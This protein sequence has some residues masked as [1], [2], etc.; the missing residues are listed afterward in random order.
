MWTLPFQAIP[1]RRKPDC[2]LPARLLGQF[3]VRCAAFT[4]VIFYVFQIK[5]VHSQGDGWKM[6]FTYF[7]GLTISCVA[8]T[9]YPPAVLR[10]P[11]DPPLMCFY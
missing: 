11:L 6:R 1:Q 2:R 4:V 7:K 9:S 10:N 5:T 8:K 3:T